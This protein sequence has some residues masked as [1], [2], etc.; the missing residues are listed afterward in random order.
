MSLSG[1]HV[2]DV[3]TEDR[4]ALAPRQCGRCRQLFDGDPT[5]NPNALPEWWVCPPCR[6]ALFGS[7][8]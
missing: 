6:S 4:G 5:L 3:P 1:T 2:S 8:H 7:P